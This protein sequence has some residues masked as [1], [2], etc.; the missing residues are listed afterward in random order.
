MILQPQCSQLGA[1]ACTAH[2][3]LS[4]V[5]ESPPGM[6]TSNALSYSLPQTSH[7]ATSTTPLVVADFAICSSR[8]LPPV[9]DEIIVTTVW[10]IGN[11]SYPGFSTGL[12]GLTRFGEDT[13]GRLGPRP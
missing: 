7:R 3:K 2:S 11:L 8:H 4:K 5:C 1:S 10:R 12:S 6:V 9:T 13:G